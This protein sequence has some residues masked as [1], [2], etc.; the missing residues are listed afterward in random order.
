MFIIIF[1]FYQIYHPNLQKKE[2]RKKKKRKKSVHK[3]SVIL[4]C[5]YC[6]HFRKLYKPTYQTP[7]SKL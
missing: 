7:L 4:F 5:M 2:E 1:T 3:I 6:H